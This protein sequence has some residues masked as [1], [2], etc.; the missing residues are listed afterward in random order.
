MSRSKPYCVTRAEAKRRLLAHWK[1]AIVECRRV[2]LPFD[3]PG[4]ARMRNYELEFELSDVLGGEWVISEWCP[5]DGI[6]T[7][8]R[9]HAPASVLRR[10][11]RRFRRSQAA[12]NVEGYN[13]DYLV[14]YLQEALAKAGGK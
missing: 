7:A 10:T 13:W 14:G 1:P 5:F 3:L 9:E 2:R 8:W 11:I 12:G 4:W 6:F